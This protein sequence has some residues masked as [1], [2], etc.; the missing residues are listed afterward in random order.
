MKMPANI[1]GALSK[2]DDVHLVGAGRCT[3]SGTTDGFVPTRP[4]VHRISGASRSKQSRE[5]V[6]RRL[7]ILQ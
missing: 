2:L 4:H 5:M 7:S 1:Q 6:S 3:A